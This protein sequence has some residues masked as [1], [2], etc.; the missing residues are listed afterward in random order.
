VREGAVGARLLQ[1]HNDRSGR[2]RSLAPEPACPTDPADMEEFLLVL[3]DDLLTAVQ[4]M[5][6]LLV[7]LLR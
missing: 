6:E 5:V 7:G 3:D 2:S 1:S 4:A